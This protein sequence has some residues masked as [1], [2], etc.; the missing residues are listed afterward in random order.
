VADSSM[1][2]AVCTLVMCSV[3]DVAAT[4]KGTSFLFL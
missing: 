2:A 1:D 3:S 4:L